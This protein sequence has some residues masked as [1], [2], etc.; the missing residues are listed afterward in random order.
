[1]RKT[2]LAMCGYKI[3]RDMVNEVKFAWAR[4][5]A[6]LTG[7]RSPGIYIKPI[8]RVSALL[9]ILNHVAQ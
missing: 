9:I 3:F 7:T 6:T 1:M 5:S 8:A 2:R 4:L